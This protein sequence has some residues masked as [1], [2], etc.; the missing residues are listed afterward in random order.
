[1]AED[2][3]AIALHRGL[4]LA[5]ID[6]SVALRTSSGS[7]RSKQHHDDHLVG[8]F[9]ASTELQ[10]ECPDLASLRGRLWNLLANDYA[11]TYLDASFVAAISA[12]R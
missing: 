7:R 5:T 9:A 3:L 6:A 11:A 8:E 12:R 4:A 1:M 2:G 10:T